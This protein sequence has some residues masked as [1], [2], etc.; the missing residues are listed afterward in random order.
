MPELHGKPFKHEIRSE[1]D[2][3]SRDLWSERKEHRI[4]RRQLRFANAK[5]EELEAKLDRIKS[6]AEGVISE[7]NPDVA[8]LAVE[9][10]SKFG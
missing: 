3:L 6:L 8:N 2:Q 1:R 9:R 10:L 4:T 5:I 7:S